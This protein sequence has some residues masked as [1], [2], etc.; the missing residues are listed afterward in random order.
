SRH[1]AAIRAGLITF[2]A[3]RLKIAV[4]PSRRPQ[5]GC[6]TDSEAPPRKTPGRLHCVIHI[7]E[8]TPA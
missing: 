2:A 4:E 5:K 1:C 3:P 8:K 6:H 7:K